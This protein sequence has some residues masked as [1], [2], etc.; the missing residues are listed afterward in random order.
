MP[1]SRRTVH[2]P[3]VQPGVSASG[4]DGHEDKLVEVY[5]QLPGLDTMTRQEASRLQ[6]TDDKALDKDWDQVAAP[7]RKVGLYQAGCAAASAVRKLG[8]APPVS[9][10]YQRISRLAWIDGQRLLPAT[11]KGP[12]E[13]RSAELGLAL[14]L[15]MGASGSP[16][17][18]V[19]ATGAL[20]GQPPGAA[21][22]DVEIL[23]VGSL[24]EKL[25]LVLTLAGHGSL[26]RFSKDD[27]LLFF[28]PRTFDDGGEARDVAS[29]A[30]VEQLKQMRVRVIPVDRLS[31]A[32][33]ALN[34]RRSRHLFA[35]HLAQAAVALI[36]LLAGGAGIWSMLPSPNVPIVFLPGGGLALDS[37]PYQACFTNDGGF[38]PIPL[39]D[40]GVTRDLPGGATLAWRVQIGAQTDGAENGLAS[41]LDQWRGGDNYHVAQ[42]M[43]SEHSRSKIIIPQSSGGQDVTIEPGGV[44][45]WAWQLIDEPENNALVL[46]ANANGP[47]DA[48]QLRGALLER[49]PEA[50]GGR[51]TGSG[52][53]ISAAAQF[54]ATQAPGS[55]RFA[56]K[57]VETTERCNS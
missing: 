26:P 1:N 47:F 17:R 10:L 25:R 44:W 13:G 52:L 57:T 42:V 4:R 54:L 6:A 20:G 41:W 24:V 8:I 3:I 32:A 11:A 15:L 23:P 34:A 7:L 9:A 18:Q 55:V 29:L 36:V 48:D 39:H 2:I 12:S 19:I 50:A 51:E 38:H 28:T 53:D 5:T 43:L 35:D 14:V 21:E 56:F 31:E 40:T 27:E 37:E 22:D 16:A 46:L 45:E 33:S 49:F 30:E